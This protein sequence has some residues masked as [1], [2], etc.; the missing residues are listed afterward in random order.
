MP[1]VCNKYLVAAVAVSLDPMASRVG[2]FLVGFVGRRIMT[3]GH[4]LTD[5]KPHGVV[6]VIFHPAP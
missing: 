5:D 2:Y 4:G 1:G 3:V 6:P